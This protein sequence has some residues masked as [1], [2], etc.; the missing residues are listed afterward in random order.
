[1]RI[2][3]FSLTP[4]RLPF[5]TP[6]KSAAG[7]WHQRQGWLVRLTDQSGHTGYGDAAPLA[8]SG[9]ETLF[10]A[11]AWLEARRTTLMDGTPERVMQQLSPTTRHPAARCGLE[12]ALLDLQSKQ[13]GLPLYRQLAGTAVHSSV[14]L[15]AAIGTLDESAGDRAAAAIA[16]GFTLL[17]L[18]LGGA[19]ISTERPRLERL[20]RQLP[21]GIGLRLDAN[22]AW[23][24]PEAFDLIGTL[25][26]LPVESLEEPLRKPDPRSLEI[27][28]SRA[29]FDLALDESLSGFIR[30]QRL[31]SIPVNRLIIKPT[32]LGG[33]IPALGIIRQ[34]HRHGL[35][36]VITSTLE[37]SAGLWP[38]LHLAASADLLTTPAIHGLATAG[39]FSRDLGNPPPLIS[40]RVVLGSEPGTGF[41]LK[42]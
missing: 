3:A 38:L 29:R 25:N 36:C 33:L 28:Q 18:K 23:Q 8:E 30:Q 22:R 34:A 42:T 16:A 21:D 20:C 12:T 4:Y 10:Q 26:Q 32:C 2:S 11:R 7:I 19:P 40:G 24:M 9:T 35:T 13:Q 17:K 14:R 15:N 6:W 37:S 1:M 41:I 5:V 39:W 31:R 27:L